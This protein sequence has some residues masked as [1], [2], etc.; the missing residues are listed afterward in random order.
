M[1]SDAFKDRF[2]ESLGGEKAYS[3]GKKSGIPGSL[4]QKYLSGTSLPGLDYLVKISEITGYN[5][6]WLATGKGPKKK[7]SDVFYEFGFSTKE[8]QARYESEKNKDTQNLFGKSVDYLRE[9][10]D[11]KDQ[12][13]ITAILSN[14]HSFS[15]AIRRE[16]EVQELRLK[17]KELSS[18]IQSME[19]RLALLEERLSKGPAE[20]RRQES[21][22]EEESGTS[23]LNGT[24]GT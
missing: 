5:V 18:K 1:N 9:I 13:F 2:L 16:Q 19:A 6:D 24:T 7:E 17:N 4:I 11:S 10:F 23:L 21:G 8:E 3:F 12:I 20:P 15:R 14:L 22:Q